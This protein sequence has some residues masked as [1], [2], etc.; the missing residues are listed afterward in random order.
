[1]FLTR[2]KF[3]TLPLRKFLFGYANPLIKLGRDVLPADKRW[4]HQTFGLF[5]GVK[6]F[7]IHFPQITLRIV[8]Y[9]FS[10]RLTATLNICPIYLKLLLHVI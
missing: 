7:L 5:V 3:E 8:G 6:L 10:S 4:P 9:H 1:M 2:K